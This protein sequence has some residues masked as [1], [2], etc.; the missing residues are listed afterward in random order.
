MC[1]NYLEFFCR[2]LSLFFHLFIQS[3][4]HLYEYGLIDIY[5]IL[6]IIIHCYFIL[7]PKLFQLWPLDT[8]S[9][10]F[11]VLWTYYTHFFFFLYFFLYFCSFLYYKML[12]YIFIFYS[13]SQNELFFLGVPVLGIRN[14][15]LDVPCS[16]CYW[17]VVISRSLS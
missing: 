15:L 3:V 5:F 6:Q 10:G 8:L 9:V 1:I 16:C 4:N 2:D 12:R 14:Q 7:L 11:Y 13:Q 17:G